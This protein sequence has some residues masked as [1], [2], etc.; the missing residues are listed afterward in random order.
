MNI[1]ENPLRIAW[2]ENSSPRWPGRLGLTIAPGKKG[3]GH[4]MQ[5]DR[6]LRTDLTELKNMGVTPLVNLMEQGE[7]HRWHMHDYHTEAAR[8]G[9]NVRHFPIPD[10]STPTDET[11]FHALAQDLHTRLQA[12]ETIVIHCLGGL[13][14]SGML[15]ACLL[16]LDGMSAQD[17]IKLVRQCRSPKAVEANQPRYVE[18]YARTHAR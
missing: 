6:D 15:A 16:V 4:D 3:Q 11:E 5:H 8:L 12:G 9:L 13:G 17:A 10:V 18:T 2:I 7:M 14:R 1:Y